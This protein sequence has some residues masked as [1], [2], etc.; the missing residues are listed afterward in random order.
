[1]KL[2]FEPNLDYQHTAIESVCD[3]FRGQEICRTEFT[4]T[5]DAVSAQQTMAFAQSDLGIGNRLQLLD[6]ELLANLG[7]IQI[8]NGLRPSAS[9]ASGDFTVE[10]ETGTGKTYVYLRS[11]F[12]LNRRYGFTKFV[13]IVPSVAIKEGV[14]KTLQI[15]E[16]H[17]RSLYANTP[18]EYFLYDSSKLGQVRNFATS[19]NIQIMVV[20]VGAINKKDVNNLYKETEKTGGE[21][22][23]DLIRAT[24]PILI[25]DE[26]QTVDGGLEGRGKE[27]LGAMNPLCTLRYSA[28]HADKHH[29]LYR[30][31]AVDAYE[32]KLVKQIEVA[33]LEV[34]GGHNKCY[35][36]LLST[37]NKKGTFTAKVELDVQ[38]GTAVNRE[39][40]NV[41]PGD[42]LQQFTGR[43]VYADCLV[44]NIGC[45][46]GEEFLELSNLEKPLRP[47]ESIGDVDGDALKRLMIRRTI[48]EHLDKELRLRPQGIKVLSLFFI[49]V[50]EYYRSY[51]AD[52]TQIKGK[53]AVMFEEEY[54]KAAKKPKYHTLFN[55]VDLESDATEVHNGYFS[56]DKKGAWTDTAENN[57]GNRENAER[58]YNLIMKDKEKLLG[59][60]TKLKFIFSHSALREGWDNPNVFQICAIREMGTE[61]ERR[62]TIGRGLR[63]CVNQE[64]ERLRGFDINTLT[65]IATEGYEQ[66]A[67]NLQKEIEE[68]TG[69]RFGIV[70]KHQFAAIPV[71]DASGRTTALGVAQSEAIWAH[72]KEAGYVDAKGKVQDQL[73]KALKENTLQLPEPFQ[74]QLPQVKEVLRKLSGKLDIK[75]A[76]ERR[77]IRTRQ[78]VLHSEEFQALWERIKHKTTYRVQF[79]NEKLLTEC[80]E[81]IRVCPPITKTR[82]Q[83][84][85][86][87]LAIG[88]GGV[89]SEETTVAAPIIIEETDIELPDLLTDLQDKTQLTRRS[90]VRIL[91]DSLRLDDFKRNPQQFVELATESI[92]RTKRLAIVDGIRYQRIGND[93]YYAQELFELEELTGYLKNML[94]ATKSVYEQVVYDSSGVERS[95]AE[96]LEKNEAVKVYAK[97]PGWF[98]VP[99]PLGTYNP[100]WAVLVEKD[101]TERLYFVVETKSSLFTDDLR[102]KESA[103]IE[104][105]KAHFKALAVGDR[106]AEFIQA[107]NIDDLMARC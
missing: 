52:G 65:V 6:D 97:L 84:R 34:E 96:Q 23:I 31:D 57:Q 86:A 92:T 10:M 41:H 90:L 5:R 89:S 45:K 59:F 50:V 21:K 87:D 43:A 14:Y 33:S 12:E 107:R 98:K 42:D 74:T 83:I 67:A 80:A 95:F 105:G 13:I 36:K 32:R 26:P 20:T 9:L 99:T 4:V 25:V 71:T 78:A 3:L 81:A 16:E 58:A 48:E 40:V 24:R 72:L 79:D 27:A 103:K 60:E 77:S 82:V 18:F 106:P 85:K 2:H 17:F 64:G 102:D 8:R 7:D 70:E 46:A 38:R 28:T 35:V 54:R 19:P 101:G 61:R 75:N 91:T 22:P 93:A 88:R 44:Q 100:D 49:D 76:D 73:R 68:D 29:M 55:E 62:Q 66:F 53:Y 94:D 11:I 15:T 1:M 30:L 56:I 37:S 63:L 69:I 47:G 104:C 51:A 39:P